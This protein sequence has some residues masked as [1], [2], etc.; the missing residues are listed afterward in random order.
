VESL[1]RPCAQPDDT[2]QYVAASRQFA[3]SGAGASAQTDSSLRGML[4]DQTALQRV[5]TLVARG[6]CHA[7][8]FAVDGQE[9]AYLLRSDAQPCCARTSPAVAQKG[10]GGRARACSTASWRRY[11]PSLS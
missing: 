9:I 7:E 11:A 5:A 2:R 6:I 4:A 1:K 8:L 10:P 3:S